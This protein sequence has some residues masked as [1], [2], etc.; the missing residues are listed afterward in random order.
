MLIADRLSHNVPAMY[1]KG[2]YMPYRLLCFNR[3]NMKP[4]F[5]NRYHLF[6]SWSLLILFSPLS[7]SAQNASPLESAVIEI[8]EQSC[9]TAG[10]HSAPIAQLNLDLSREQFYSGLVDEPSV[11]Q[12]NMKRV[13]PGNP[14]G[15]YLLKKI[16]GDEDIVG[17]PMPMT[18]DRLSSEQIQTISDWITELGPVDVARKEAAPAPQAIPFNGWKIVNLPTNRMIP[19][20]NFLFLISHRFNPRISDGYDAL[21]GLDGSGIIFLNL[22]YAISD[23]LLINLGRSNADDDVEFYA[24]YKI[25]DQN[26]EGGWPVSVGIQS[27][28]NW[29]SEKQ[30]GQKRLRGEVL[31]FATQVMITRNVNDDFGV[32]LVPGIL[33]NPSPQEDSEDPMLTVGVGGRWHFYRNFS[34]TAE[35]VPIVSGFTRTQ[36]FGNQNRFDSWGAG[37][38]I[39]TGG[40]VFQ[41]LVSNSVGLATD[42]YLRGGD[43]DIQEGDVRLGFN[44]FRILN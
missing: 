9:A 14:E 18:G 36:T 42:Q 2:T 16:R 24:K 3:T 35:W 4:Y 25:A 22:G 13:D 19:K 43:L 38:E 34:L 39:A 10:C 44:I 20:G 23:D 21:F 8:F 28:I 37:L 1:I 32:G 41:I 6:L 40:H 15:S 30:A 29:L 26:L 12:P 17:L 33:F 5:H 11:S 7:L 27:S 31:K